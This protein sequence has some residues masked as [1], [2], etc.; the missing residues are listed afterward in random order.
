MTNAS[1]PNSPPTSQYKSITQSKTFW[2]ALLTA[3]AA[4]SPAMADIASEYKETKNIEPQSIS[5]IVV[6]LATTGLTI[7]GRLDANNG[8]SVYT[9]NWAPGPNKP[10]PIPPS[11]STK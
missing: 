10:E 3:V 7:I 1:L 2:G 8:A 5:E 9:P 4:V 6:I 11:P